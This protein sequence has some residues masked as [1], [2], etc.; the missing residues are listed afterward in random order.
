MS[1][2]NIWTTLSNLLA[3]TVVKASPVTETSPGSLQNNENPW[4]E[5]F[6]KIKETNTF[7]YSDSPFMRGNRFD[8]SL[9][10]QDC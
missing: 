10:Y 2:L 4:C 8:A 9:V 6:Y 3:S 7:D 1:L 5:I